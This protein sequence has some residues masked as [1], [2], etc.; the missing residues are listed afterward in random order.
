[1]DQPKVERLLRMIQMLAS[2]V[3]YSV[4]DLMDRLGMSRRTVYRY[5]DT[6]KEA[7]FAVQKVNPS[8]NVYR[9]ATM[10]K[11]F[12]D[13]S[14]L[15]YF[16]DEE[17]FIVNSLM[18]QLDNNSPIKQG[19]RRKL[20]AVYDISTISS[21]GGRKANSAN[22]GML[23]DAIKD[24][25]AVILKGYSSSHSKTTKDYKVEPYRLNNNYI[26]IWAYDLKD[27]INKRFKVSRIGEVEVLDEPWAFEEKHEDEPLD[28]FRMHG[29][30]PMHVKLRLD[31]VAK[32]LLVEEYPMAEKGLRADGDSWIWE[33]DVRRVDGVGRFVLGLPKFVEVLEGE[34][35]KT[36]LRENAD[37]I[38]SR[39]KS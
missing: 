37:Y 21:F 30:E 25:C 5:L 24:K 8:G 16:S 4:D 18:D 38:L 2:N 29:G 15:V 9:L 32:N 34:E 12:A 35:L 27:G 39:V 1:M 19:L 11:P 20:A 6:F 22:I 17:A 26:D 36:F 3:D 14:K 10:R 23:T 31:Y 13:L 28:A 7:G 33:G